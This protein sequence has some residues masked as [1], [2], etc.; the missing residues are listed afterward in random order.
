[1]RN[2]FMVA[3]LV[4]LSCFGPFASP[5]GAVAE[6]PSDSAPSQLH[7]P[8]RPTGALFEGTQGLQKTETTYDPQ[9]NT[10]TLKLLV[11][12]P[13]AYSIPVLPRDNFAVFKNGPRQHNATVEVERSPVS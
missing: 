3:G 7:T 13:N 1:M 6:V 11:Q 10:V 2:E 8:S 5:H 4:G 9:T 12:D